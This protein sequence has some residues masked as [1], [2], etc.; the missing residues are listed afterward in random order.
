MLVHL[1]LLGISFF[2][3]KKLELPLKDRLMG[4]EEIKLTDVSSSSVDQE[5]EARE[6]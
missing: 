2:F 1:A 5:E 3:D 6:I 4:T